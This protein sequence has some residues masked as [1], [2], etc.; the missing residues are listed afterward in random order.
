MRQRGKR[1]YELLLLADEQP[2]PPRDEVLDF[3]RL[4]ALTDRS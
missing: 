2:P 1:L 4:D 3:P